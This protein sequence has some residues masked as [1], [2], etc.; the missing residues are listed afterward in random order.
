M[1]LR[2]AVVVAAEC[3]DLDCRI[4]L[5]LVA[6]V[7][8]DFDPSFRIDRRFAAGAVGWYFGSNCR[9]GPLLA[10]P[11]SVDCWCSMIQIVL[12]PAVAGFVGCWYSKIRTALHSAVIDFAEYLC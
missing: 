12:H 1:S 10:D 3:F 9:K 8:V 2:F 4:V 11:H 6:F 7:A 5:R